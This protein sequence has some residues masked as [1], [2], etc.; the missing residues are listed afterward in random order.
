MVYL[1]NGL[2]TASGQA[3]A[4]EVITL[5]RASLGNAGFVTHP[6]KSVWEP[7]QCLIC[8]GLIID[9]AQSEIG[10]PEVIVTALREVL[11]QTIAVAYVS[12]C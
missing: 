12:P 5:V 7:T 3:S 11:S 1:D 9:L 2:C 10:I 8:L 6:D 4:R